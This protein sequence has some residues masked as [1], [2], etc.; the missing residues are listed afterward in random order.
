MKKKLE[1]KFQKNKILLKLIDYKIIYRR[2]KAR[3][4]T[5]YDLFNIFIILEI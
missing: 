2:R 1:G 4:I 3:E 5:R